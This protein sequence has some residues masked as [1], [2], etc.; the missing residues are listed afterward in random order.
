MQVIGQN[1][2]AAGRCSW[3]RPQHDGTGAVAEQHA[4][5]AVLPIEDAREGLGADDQSCSRLTEAQRVI[6]DRK[7]KNKPRI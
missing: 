2:A 7:G 6:G 4:G 3:D 1:K 5:A